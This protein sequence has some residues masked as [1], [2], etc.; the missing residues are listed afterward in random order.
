MDSGSSDNDDEIVQFKIAVLGN[1]AVGKSSLIQ[2]F[3]KSGFNQNYKQT[4][5]LD[6]YSKKVKLPTS[7]DGKPGPEV[8][9]H[10]WDVGGQQIGGSMLDNYVYGSDAVCLVF[11]VTNRDSLQD[12]RYWRD[13]VHSAYNAG[14]NANAKLPPS[15][16]TKRS[17]PRMYLV[18]NKVDLPHSQIDTL[19]AGLLAE[20]GENCGGAL[21][22]ARS[23]QKVN[24]LFTQI[25]ADLCG[26]TI[27]QYDL[28]LADQAT[29]NVVSAPQEE[30]RPTARRWCR[31]C[32]RRAIAW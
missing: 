2:Y 6:F 23:G 8:Q 32:T 25:A 29:A 5:G 10:I 17:F 7:V 16:Q 26:V 1:G 14:S 30:R 20:F 21:V 15:Q 18:G 13:A 4:I 3:C 31:V 24:A 22:S 12:L 19:Q 11:D 28:D 27:K 9:L